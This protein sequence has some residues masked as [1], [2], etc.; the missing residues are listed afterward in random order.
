MGNSASSESSLGEA[1]GPEGSGVTL[2]ANLQ[3][4]IVNDFNAKVHAAWIQRSTARKQEED[5]NSELAQ[6]HQ[7]F[8]KH[9]SA[10]Q[11]KLDERMDALSAKFHDQ[12][13]SADYDAAQLQQKYVKS[14]VS[15]SHNVVDMA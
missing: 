11:T 14:D 7:Q 2:S 13:V 10:T 4:T 3:K 9:H 8:L 5:A 15:G 6:Q 1:G 12:V